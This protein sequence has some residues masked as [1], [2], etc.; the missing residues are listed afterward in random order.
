VSQGQSNAFI[1]SVALITIG[2]GLELADE[3]AYSVSSMAWA[4]HRGDCE[5]YISAAKRPPFSQLVKSAHYC[6]AIIDFAKDI[7]QAI[8]TATYIQ[9]MFSGKAAL[10][11]RS[12][13][14][15]PDILLRSMRAGCNDFIGG[16]FNEAAFSETLGRINQLWSTK[17]ASNTVRGSVLTFLGAKGGVGTTTLAVHVAIYLV[18][19][20]HKR[21]LLIDNHPQLGHVCVYLGIDGSR[22]NFH[23]LVRNLSR[24]D[25]ELLRGYIATHSSG[26]EVLSSP[27]TCGGRKATDPESMAQ[28]LDFLRG[29]YDYVIVDS[30][31][32]LDETNL[33][34]IEASNQVYLVATPEIGAV[35]DLSRNVDTL[36]QNEHNQERVKVIIN[37]FSSQHAVSLEQIEKAIRL[38]VFIKLPNNYAEVVRSGILGEPIS[39]KQKSEFGSQILKWVSN[40][41]GPMLNSEEVALKKAG[42]SLWK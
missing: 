8:E 11:A 12:A 7:D 35:R 9:E 36:S 41:A 21:V 23:E 37:R 13:S 19:C 40:L 31:T 2:L 6:I 20:H 42:F 16:Q 25:S 10:V 26:L 5:G 28:T 15:D 3:I 27:D 32:S 22:Y 33:A 4:V 18:Q 17:A 30:P 39:H 1:P 24:L 34:V 29:E 14:Q 38:P